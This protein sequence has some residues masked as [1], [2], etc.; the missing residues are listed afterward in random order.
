MEYKTFPNLYMCLHGEQSVVLYTLVHNASYSD[1]TTLEFLLLPLL[2]KMEEMKSTKKQRHCECVCVGVCVCVCVCVGG[3][4]CGWVGVYVC[5]GVCGCVGVCWFIVC[6]S[7]LLAEL[8]KL[9]VVSCDGGQK[10][11]EH[12]PTCILSNT[13][14]N[15]SG[16][17][18][19]LHMSIMIFL[20]LISC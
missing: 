7:L 8:L 12:G 4:V 10:D 14:D 18:Y 1:N 5:V 16:G 11:E 6:P 17:T 15:S 9:E 2:K 20:D 19:T 3:C 13:P